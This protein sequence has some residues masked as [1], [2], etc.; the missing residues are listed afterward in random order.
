M[1]FAFTFDASACSGC[2]ACQAACKDKNQLPMGVLW[3]RVYEISGGTWEQ[4]GDAWN[5]TVFA[6]NM[7]LACNHCEHPKC[8]GVCPTNAYVIRPDGIVYIDES[9]C[10]GCGYCAW[11]CPYGVP[12]YNSQTGHMTKC[13]FCYDNIDS[14]LAPA[15]VAACPMRV[16][17]Y[18]DINNVLTH[19]GYTQLWEVPGAKHPYPLP[20]F[21]RTEPHLSVKPHPA[22]QVVEEKNIANYEET[23][24][25]KKTA[26]EEVPLVIFTLL[27]QMAVGGFWSMMWMFP[28]L[29]N[30]AQGDQILLRA[31]PLLVVGVSLGAGMLAS[32]AH[33]GA[34]KNAWRVLKHLRKSCLSREILF[35]G[36]F[37]AGW[38]AVMM[39]NFIFRSA[40]PALFVVAAVLGYFLIHSMSQVYHLR[41]RPIW[42]TW[43]TKSAFMISA[44]LLGPLVMTPV[45][46]HELQMTGVTIPDFLWEATGVIS[47]ALFVAQLVITRIYHLEGMIRF[48]H[49]GLSLAAMFA[50]V[51]TFLPHGQPTIW[52]SL[53]SLLTVLVEEVVGRWSFYE[54]GGKS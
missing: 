17:D 6:Y 22:M 32:F 25:R 18:R 8:A 5:N 43:R 12:Q 51:F 54:M 27:A 45:L 20:F 39:E 42:N 21:S 23:Q 2:K 34:R 37:G 38:L 30:L 35:V 33:L 46:V 24:S 36:L 7:S 53:F 14:G 4:N 16:L 29:W 11:A 52:G 50:L 49:T 13:N 40:T 41:A 19:T 48:L 47:I 26:W 9:K 28:P 3:R 1:T 10:I 15:C 31:L 44:L